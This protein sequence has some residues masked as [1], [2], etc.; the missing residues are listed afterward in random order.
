MGF[1]IFKLMKNTLILLF[2][3]IFATLGHAQEKIQWMTIEEAY[4]LT[5]TEESPKDIY[6]RLYGLVWMVQE[7]G[8]GY[9]SKTRSCDVYERE[10]L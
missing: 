8:Q 5:T 7:N 1:L 9:F 10:F 4:A 2:T 6:R 3:L